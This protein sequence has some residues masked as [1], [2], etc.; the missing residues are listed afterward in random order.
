MI[1]QIEPWIDEQELE[2]LK[3]VVKSTYVVEHELTAEFEEQTRKLTGARHAIAVTNGTLALFCCLK[4]LDIGPG[5]EVIV[6]NMTF[7]A[8]ANAV[9]MAGARPVFCEILP[10]TFCMDPARAEALINAH[11]KAIIPVHLYGQSADIV[12]LTELAKRKGLPLIEDAAQ[13]VGVRFAGKHVGTFGNM[14]ILSYYGNKTVT[15]G[16]GG[17]ILTDNDE[18]ARKTYRLK[19][20]GRDTK[21]VFIHEHIGFNFSFTEMQ[22]AVGIAQMHKLPAIIAKKQTIYDRYSIALNQL[23]WFRPVQIDPRCSPVFWFTSYLCDDTDALAQYMN[24]HG[25]QTR[26]FFYPLHLQPCYK[27]LPIDRPSFALSEKIYAQ[28]ISLP[29]AYN[30]TENDQQRVIDLILK[31]YQ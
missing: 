14:G 12:A 16:E 11:T 29:S 3:R 7:I 13:G 30:L 18:L 31:Y 28:G 21:G 4:A 17:M 26:R 2:Q 19:N 23:E 5:D 20:H 15:C 9:I 10:T 22:A 27:H 6:P 8:T 25:V 1:L 24:E